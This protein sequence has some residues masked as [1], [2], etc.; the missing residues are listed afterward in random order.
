MPKNEDR[1]VVML[2]NM[3]YGKDDDSCEHMTKK[4]AIR[5]LKTIT[6][7]DGNGFICKLVKV[8]NKHI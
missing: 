2:D 4:R 5:E 6:D 8:D 3:V 1:Y 7:W